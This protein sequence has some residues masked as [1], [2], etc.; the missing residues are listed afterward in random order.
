MGRPTA[1]PAALIVVLALV[2]A[3]ARPAAAAEPPPAG[4]GE[5]AWEVHG[6]LGGSTTFPTKLTIRQLDEDAFDV[7]HAEYETRPMELPLYYAYRVTRW[8][9]RRAWAAEFVHHKLFLE[10]PPPRIQDFSVSHGY[11]LLT[12][13][14][15]WWVDGYVVGAGVGIVIAHPENRVRGRVLV[16]NGGIGDYVVA[17]P[18][19]AVTAGRRWAMGPHWSMSWE[20]RLS[21]AYARVP[22]DDGHASVPDFSAHVILGVGRRVGW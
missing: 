20:G 10:D 16:S 13:S 8:Q 15:L 11:N 1:L 5:T 21:A 19:G 18:T 6:Y 7:V 22:I 14:R 17:G 2:S 12:A 9:G 3:C 4:V